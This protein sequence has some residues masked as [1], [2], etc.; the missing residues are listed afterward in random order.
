MRV[1]WNARGEPGPIANRI[2]CALRARFRDETLKHRVIQYLG[3][4][5]KGAGA[6]GRR[7]PGGRARDFTF[8][9]REER[10]AAQ[11]RVVEGV[12][13]VQAG[14]RPYDKPELLLL[15]QERAPV[16]AVSMIRAR[17]PSPRISSRAWISVKLFELG[18]GMP[19]RVTLPEARYDEVMT[20]LVGEVARQRATV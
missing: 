3:G 20:K 18:G 1:P 19:T 5:D 11:Y 14:P 4:A 16:S 15:G 7:S 12:A 2:D 10:L 9:S 6:C 17:S 8:G 13:Y